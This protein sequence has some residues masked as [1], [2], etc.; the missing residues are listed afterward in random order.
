MLCWSLL[1]LGHGLEVIL[2]AKEQVSPST[3]V[4]FKGIATS[5]IC[6]LYLSHTFLQ[7]VVSQHKMKSSAAIP[8]HYS[9]KHTSF[10]YY[11]LS[12][13][14]DH[15]LGFLIHRRSCEFTHSVSPSAAF[16]EHCLFGF[17]GLEHPTPLVNLAIRDS[18][19]PVSSNP[20]SLLISLSLPALVRVNIQRTVNTEETKNYPLYCT[21]FAKVFSVKTLHRLCCCFVE[22]TAAAA[23]M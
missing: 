23:F 17:F 1:K 16:A 20:A 9:N 2:S 21:L 15:I 3:T 13:K 19:L 10:S 12:S 7:T 8:A 22:F 5:W 4:V 6:I 11:I 14:N 18:S